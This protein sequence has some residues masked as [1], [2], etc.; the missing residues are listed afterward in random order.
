MHPIAFVCV[1]RNFGVPAHCLRLASPA[2][3]L[4]II[5]CFTGHDNL[6][7][8]FLVEFFANRS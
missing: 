2:C 3:F 7:H 8:H 6:V 5:A 1:G 4:S